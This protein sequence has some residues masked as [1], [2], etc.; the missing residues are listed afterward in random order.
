MLAV[1]LALGSSLSWGLSDFVGGLQSRRQALL[2][3][4]WVSQSSAF[5]VL[6]AVA[7]AGAPTDHDA[8]ASAW[9][10]GAGLF[11]LCGLAAF[12]RALSI[13]TMSIVA[14]LSATGTVIP[15][16]VGLMSGERPGP[17]QA[18]GIALAA[19]GVV[20]A[21][22]EA[23]AEDDRARDDSRRSIVLALVAAVGFGSFFAGVDRAEESADVVWV[24]VMAR[25]PTSLILT[26]LVLA[27]RPPMPAN[28]RALGA[29]LLIGVV[30]LLANVLF[31]LATGTGLLSIVG[32]LGSLYP[33]VTVVLAR[34]LL[35][36]RPTR[37]QDAGV[38]ITLAG[39]VAIAAG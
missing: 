25:L 21:A 12:Y 11:G 6:V 8:A 26:A 2:T 35:H 29:L 1:V 33:A 10:A 20:L 16:L 31:T 9:A 34:T 7:V 39:V 37:V 32:V 36:E 5:L 30:D 22:R 18:I 15:V 24:L 17:M 27:R 14:P 13:G 23:P 3:V 19:C 28:P 4:L 38:V